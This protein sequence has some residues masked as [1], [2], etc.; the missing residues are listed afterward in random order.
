M[1]PRVLG[2]LLLVALLHVSLPTPCRAIPT[3]W[4]EL[5]GSPLAGGAQRHDDLWFLNPDLGWLVN[6]DGEIWRTTDGGHTWSLQVDTGVYNR[7]VAFLDDSRGYVGTLYELSGVAL[8]ESKDGGAI[9]VPMNLPE[10]KP[11]GICGLYALGQNVYGV[12]AYYGYPRFIRSPDGG[13]SWT[14][15]DMSP[16]V[17]ALVDTYFWSPD[18][19]IAVGSTIPGGSRR[20]RVVMTTD[21]GQTWS[22]RWT[23][24]RNR[25]ICWKISFVNR[26]VGFVSIENLNTS[27]AAYFLK[28]VDGGL[29]WTERLFQPTYRNV[30]GIGFL[31]EVEGWIGGWEFNTEFT[32]NGGNTWSP[33]GFGFNVNRFRF[34][35]PH[36]GYACGRKVY[37]YQS[38]PSAVADG[39]HNA[40]PIL[41][42]QNQ[43]NPFAAVTTIPYRVTTPGPVQLRLFDLQGREVRTLF[44]GPRAAGDFTARFEA[45]ELPAGAYFYR[46]TTR[47][48]TETRK[49]QILR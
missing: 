47:T 15:K 22:V 11:R 26:Q 24:T 6:G 3:G 44:D 31:S 35:G 18:S 13:V 14:S 32:G 9:W 29:T 37:K 12:G 38:E 25:E 27:G 10:P 45:L 33:A 28:T 40:A 7:A 36:L 46:L 17:G 30:Q 34:L 48:G 43:P 21:G 4:S 41:L 20:A 19:G 5:P 39:P 2:V 23:G 49:L 8:L 42:G 1:F 16:W